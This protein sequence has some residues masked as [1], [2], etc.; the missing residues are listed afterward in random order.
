LV[1]YITAVATLFK[2]NFMDTRPYR[3][4]V[5]IIIVK[6]DKILVGKRMDKSKH[7]GYKFPGGG[8]DEGD[9]LEQTVIKEALEEVGIQTEDVTN[10]GLTFRYNT[11]YKD[12]ER[13]KIFQGGI[14][15]WM[16]ARYVRES[17]RLFNS[18][19]DTF[20]FLWQTFED[21]TKTVNSYKKDQ[22]TDITI[23]AIEQ[24]RLMLGPKIEPLKPW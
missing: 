6:K 5:R 18:Q 19:G 1:T 12:P 16:A 23:Q 24:A 3:P 11:V 13:A 21:A 14:D 17:K 8:I 4:A 7:I 9:S 2:E 20:P 10:L 15:T 22:Y